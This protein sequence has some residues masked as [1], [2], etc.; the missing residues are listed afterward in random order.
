MAIKGQG[1]TFSTFWLKALPLG[2]LRP[3]SALFSLIFIDLTVMTVASGMPPL[4]YKLNEMGKEA[5]S[6]RAWQ[7]GMMLIFG[8]MAKET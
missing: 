4:Q 3:P 8:K 1:H 6:L 5:G 7:A 2:P